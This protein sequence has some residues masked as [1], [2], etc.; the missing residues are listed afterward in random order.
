MLG[1]S[2]LNQE[3]RDDIAAGQGE[4]IEMAF[5]E[6]NKL[7]LWQEAFAISSCAQRHIRSRK[8]RVW[9]ELISNAFS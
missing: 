5:C 4:E 1:C 8:H 6:W 2:L 3:R 9:H 7:V